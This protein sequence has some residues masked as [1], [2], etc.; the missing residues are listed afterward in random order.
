MDLYIGAKKELEPFEL[1]LTSTYV[2][3][4][5][6]RDSLR[7]LSYYEVKF[8]INSKITDASTSGVNIYYSPNYFEE[9][10]QNLIFE[11]VASYEFSQFG[12][13][14]PT[15]IGEIGY[16]IGDRTSNGYNYG[17]Y[18]I[19]L[20]FWASAKVITEIRFSDS[21]DVPYSCDGQCGKI[22]VLGLKI[23]N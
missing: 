10:G 9:V 5:T 6:S 13:L 20:D 1:N 7:E 15:V 12:S 8:G 4:A 23:R 21:F 3:Y 17:Y 11:Y 16:Q 18:D 19:R 22:F 2:Y 14:R